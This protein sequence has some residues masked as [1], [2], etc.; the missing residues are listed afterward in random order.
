MSQD[1]HNGESA[2][3]MLIDLKNRLE[4]EANVLLTQY[5]NSEVIRPHDIGHILKGL[6]DELPSKID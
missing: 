3:Q 2:M 4:F 6:A 1:L 5:K